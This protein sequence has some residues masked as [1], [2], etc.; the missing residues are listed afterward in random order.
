MTLELNPAET[1][2]VR[3]ALRAWQGQEAHNAIL[4]HQIEEILERIP[5]AVNGGPGMNDERI[6]RIE[7]NLD[8]L[9]VMVVN[10]ADAV[11]RLERVSGV[12]LINDEEL[13]RRLTALEGKA[14]RRPQ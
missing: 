7:K 11:Q 9:T 12:L 4:V 10:I 5:R 3:A 13:D 14:P 2:I 8:K 1:A 6:E